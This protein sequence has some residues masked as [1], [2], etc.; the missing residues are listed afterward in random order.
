MTDEM[1]S[2]A[3]PTNHA[4]KLSSAGRQVVKAGRSEPPNTNTTMAVNVEASLSGL[5]EGLHL[6]HAPCPD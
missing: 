2:Q 3:N 6:S 1:T 4:V 5:L